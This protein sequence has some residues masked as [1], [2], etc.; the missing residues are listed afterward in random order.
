MGS[1]LL[2]HLHRIR[3]FCPFYRG[4]LDLPLRNNVKGNDMSGGYRKRI[5]EYN[6]SR[7]YFISLI[8][9][10]GNSEE[11]E[12]TE[13]VYEAIIDSQREKWRIDKRE[14]RHCVHLD[15]IPECYLPHSDI[16]DD[17]E[18]ALIAKQTA[19]EIEAAL[20]QIPIK[21]KRRFLLRY[22]HDMPIKRIASLEGCSERSVK[23]SLALARKNL[24]DII[25]SEE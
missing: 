4:A 12:V 2:Q 19:S 17:P 1:F 9:P 15:C 16:K 5:S 10:N 20:M 24:K 7:K 8:L 14:S 18:Y 6:G 22:V 3:S 21:Q 25:E 11:I 13:E 23:Y